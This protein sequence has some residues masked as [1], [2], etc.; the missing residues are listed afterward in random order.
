VK[1][2]STLD[3]VLPIRK[4]TPSK[5]ALTSYYAR[6]FVVRSQKVINNYP[7]WLCNQ[8]IA[9]SMDKENGIVSEL[10]LSD[11]FDPAL[12]LPRLYSTLAQRFVSF[13]GADIKWCF[14]YHNRKEFF[15]VGEFDIVTA[16][17][18][19]G[20]VMVGTRP[21]YNRTDG[22][23][24]ILVDKN[25]TLY[26]LTKIGTINELTVL[27][28]IEDVL[29][30]QGRSP[31]EQLDIN[32]YG[33]NIPLG[34]FL[35]YQIG[36]SS[37]L[38]LLKI[39][40]R[41]VRHGERVQLGEDEYSI[42]FSDETWIFQRDNQLAAGVLSGFRLVS[43]VTRNFRS[44]VF[45]RKDI[46]FNA[47]ESLGLG[48]R[49]LREM[50]L[51]VDMF[52]DPITKEILESLKEPTDFIH[53]VMKAAEMLQTDWSP[54]ETDM[55]QMRIR[56]YER[57]AGAVYSELVKAM[58]T[59]Q[60]SK[61]NAN[62][63][64]EMPPYA[65]WNAISQ[66]PAVALI[67]ESN[68]V[69]NL[70][71]K[72]EVTYAG[73]GGRSKRSMVKRT[74]VFH[75]GDMGVIS[76]ATKDSSDAGI[77]TFLTADPNL[78]DLRGLTKPWDGKSDASK[79]LSTT[80][81]LMPCSDRD[82]PRRTNF[83]SI[84][85]SS[86]TSSVG[87]DVYPVRTGY[88]QILAHRVDDLFA[89]TA[90]A[91]GVVSAVSPKAVTVTYKDGT[92]KS[93]ELGRRYGTAAGAIMPHQI[94]TTLVVGDKVRK[95]DL[96]AHNSNY[97]KV[98]PFD[99][100]QAIWKSGVLVKTAFMECAD[101]FEDSSV[102][103][104][105][106][107]QRLATPVTK[108]R[109]IVVRFDQSLHQMVQE[110][111]EVDAES[112][113]CTIEDPST[114]HNPLFDDESLNTLRLLSAFT[115]RAKYPGT[116]ERIEVFYNGELEDMSES[117]REVTTQSDRVRRATAKQLNQ[118]YTSGAVDA[119]LHVDKRPLE[120]DS[121]VIRVYITHLQ[122]MGVGDKSVFGNQLKSIV[123]RIMSGRNETLSGTPIGAFFAYSSV[124]DR[125]VLSPEIMGTTS[126]L[127][128]VLSKKVAAEYFGG[129]EKK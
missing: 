24:A 122:P 16:A 93:V 41:V 67:E 104:E 120:I 62:N 34:V 4:V 97:F 69:H 80:A 19:N 52:I 57:I 46:Y 55:S 23:P 78:V 110:N 96:V 59:F 36:I 117:L 10:K 17:E 112:I 7:K 91:D 121:L 128:G 89:Y 28:K 56:G 49:Y 27:G 113:L 22:R 118:T 66:D 30:L 32:I 85:Q 109:E 18:K 125:I 103:S 1:I 20:M 5:V 37:L 123:G 9:S 81:L 74:R 47:L 13:V 82:D 95:G 6:L 115:P 58:R 72:E 76:E 11:V 108:V 43:D 107:A 124:S 50:D 114:A 25:D 102:I 44:D 39:K 73:T 63:S 84:Q 33:K 3:G 40:P 42:A 119:T 14:D 54:E 129:S 88:E 111:D 15:T 106:T 2:W 94:E 29:K 98:D 45:D 101:T 86:S 127:L 83:A 35:A 77:T 99:H 79:L 12:R 31:V 21:T 61:G 105:A 8:I 53:L 92:S 116:V 70:K 64:V 26:E 65:V 60:R 100:K 51:V 75:G 48:V 90:K 68:P 87:Y 71:E 38:A 126:T